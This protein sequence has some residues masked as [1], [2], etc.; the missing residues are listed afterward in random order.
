VTADDPRP[1]GELFNDDWW[2]A[3]YLATSDGVDSVPYAAASEYPVPHAAAFRA[4]AEP[5][6]RRLLA[7]AA[8]V[9]R[10]REL[11]K[12]YGGISTFYADEVRRALDGDR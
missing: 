5:F 10:V 1:A 6:L 4:A 11:I 9:Q 2:T 3:L 12:G 7:D 8:K